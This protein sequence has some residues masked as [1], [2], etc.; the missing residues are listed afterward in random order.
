MMIQGEKEAIF[1]GASS[2]WCFR[3][4]FKIPISI[5]NYIEVCLAQNETVSSILELGFL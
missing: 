1:C 3:F 2:K 5:L 4:L